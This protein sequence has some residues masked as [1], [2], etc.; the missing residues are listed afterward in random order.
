MSNQKIYFFRA[1]CR[2]S[3]TESSSM[4]HHSEHR[5]TKTN[6]HQKPLAKRKLFFTLKRMILDMINMNYNKEHIQ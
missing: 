3:R 1:F 4:I 5:P 6:T 2:V